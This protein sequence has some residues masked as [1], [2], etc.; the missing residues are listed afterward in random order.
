[1]ITSVCNESEAVLCSNVKCVV[2]F[3]RCLLYTLCCFCLCKRLC[4][5]SSRF[6][7]AVFVLRVPMGP[8]KRNLFFKAWRVREKKTRSVKY[9]NQLPEGP[10]VC[11]FHDMSF[12]N[13]HWLANAYV[14]YISAVCLLRIILHKIVGCAYFTHTCALVQICQITLQICVTLMLLG[15]P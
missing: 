9:L 5:F 13:C 4:V 6:V 14:L 1:M 7:A 11:S 3:T 2:F 8:R 15:S 10:W 12:V